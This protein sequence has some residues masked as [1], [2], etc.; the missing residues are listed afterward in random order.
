MTRSID[1][2]RGPSCDTALRPEDWVD[3][4]GDS[5]YRY[6]L[7]RIR[8]PEAAADVVQETFLEALRA[9]R[10]FEGRSSERTW[11]VGILRHKIV[12]YFR[13]A[14][15][16]RERSRA[17]DRLEPE[18]DQRGHWRIGPASWRGEP[19]RALESREFWQV[20]SRC[21]E[22]LPPSLSEAFLLREL[23]GTD[24]DDVQRLLKITPA[25]L[26]TR[27]HRARSLLRRCLEIHWFER[28][29]APSARE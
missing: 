29:T 21:L 14:G 2:R 25:N 1:D 16:Q 23:D 13:K 26:W 15:R 3:L 9:Q 17:G 8:S 5:L 27:L 19:A 12:D 6:A 11:L 20:F 7:L 28:S 22:Q 18:F 24:A 4:H 10:A